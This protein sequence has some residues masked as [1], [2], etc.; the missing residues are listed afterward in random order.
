MRLLLFW[1]S[2]PPSPSLAWLF[3]DSLTSPLF[4]SV[5]GWIYNSICRRRR[6]LLVLPYVCVS[7]S[8]SFQWV[9]SR[10]HLPL[11]RPSVMGIQKEEE[12]E[13]IFVI[14]DTHN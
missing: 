13:E 11:V 1:S 10:N 4:S 5:S 3:L 9:G 7:L 6:R 14:I 8:L 12:E 2:D